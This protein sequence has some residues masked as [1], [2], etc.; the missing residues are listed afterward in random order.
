M[1]TPS[2][3]SFTFLSAPPFFQHPAFFQS[4]N[5]RTTHLVQL[6]DGDIGLLATA[7]LVQPHLPAAQL[8]KYV[9]KDAPLL[10]LP[11][12]RTQRAQSSGPS[13]RS[14]RA[15]GSQLAFSAKSMAQ[16]CGP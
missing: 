4:N 14:G 2:P 5:I 13:T 10:Q 3:P 12:Q 8:L 11:A 9:H 6:P 15:G 1:L 16:D 7:P